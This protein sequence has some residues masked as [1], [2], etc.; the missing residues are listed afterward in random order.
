MRSRASANGRRRGRVKFRVAV[1]S[2]N[3]ICRFHIED[4]IRFEKS[5][6]VKIE[7]GHDNVLASD[8][9][10]TA[11]WYQSGRTKPLPPL[12]AVESRLPRPDP[13]ELVSKW[14]SLGADV[15]ACVLDEASHQPVEKLRERGI[16]DSARVDFL[17]RRRQRV[18][19]G[20]DVY[21]E[22]F[23]RDAQR[24]ESAVATD[25]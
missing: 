22:Y 2:K 20:I 9:S 19:V 24:P 4:P 3:S 11:Y 16:V 8:Y 18:H 17:V 6:R 21:S 15:N 25:Q 12:A 23:E 5:I 14:R 7:T 13:P 1:G 10:S